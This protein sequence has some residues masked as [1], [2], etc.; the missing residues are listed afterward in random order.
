MNPNEELPSI[1]HI[2]TNYTIFSEQLNVNINKIYSQN[3]N[4]IWK[5]ILTGYKHDYKQEKVQSYMF[6]IHMQWI[7]YWRRESNSK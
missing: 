2:E 1:K 7:C 6:Q 4:Q 5:K 3:I